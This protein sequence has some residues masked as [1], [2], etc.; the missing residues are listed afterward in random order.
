MPPLR[1]G[2]TSDVG[3]YLLGVI[4][5]LA[6]GN[7]NTTD[8]GVL[9]WSR[10]GSCPCEML[11]TVAVRGVPSA[12]AAGVS[13]FVF[14][15]ASSEARCWNHK[16]CLFGIITVDAGDV[17]PRPSFYDVIWLVHKLTWLNITDPCLSFVQIVFPQSMWGSK[18]RGCCYKLNLPCLAD[19]LSAVWWPEENNSAFFF[20]F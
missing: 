20:F 5:P 4:F 13:D 3:P 11:L 14:S 18:G 17:S 2:L 16:H 7:V 12:V 8:S 6:S 19:H 15:F 9:F 1:L 10:K